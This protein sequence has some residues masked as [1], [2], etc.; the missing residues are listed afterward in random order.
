MSVINDRNQIR[1]VMFVWGVLTLLY[2]FTTWVLVQ[3]V[4]QN[5]Q[6]RIFAALATTVT[7]SAIALSLGQNVLRQTTATNR[8]LQE[9]NARQHEAEAQLR[10]ELVEKQRTEETLRRINAELD[11]LNATTLGLLNRLN[12]EELF[13]RIIARAAALLNT[14][15]GFL[16]VVE[17]EQQELVMRAGVGRYTEYL[18]HRLTRGQGMSGAVWEIGEPM[19]L[20]DYSQ[21]VNRQPG[22]EWVRAQVCL[23]L[24]VGLTIVGVIGLVYLE[25]GRYFSKEAI[26]LLGRFGQLASLALENARL[27][28]QVHQELQ[29]RQHA[30]QQLQETLTEIERAQTKANAIFDAT[31]DSMLLLAP[32]Q[33]ILAVNRSFCEHFFGSDPR[34]AFGHPLTDYQAEAQRLFDPPTALQELIAQTIADTEQSFTQNI[35][36]RAPQR[37]VIQLF[38]TPV[39]T[40]TAEHLGRLYVFRDVTKEREVDRMKSEFVSMVSHELR[41][42]LTSIKGYVDLL[43]TGEV[44]ELANE[45]REFLDIVKTNTD[46]LVELINELL[47][48]SRIEAGGVELKRAALDLPRLVQ[49]VADAMLPQLRAKQHRLTLDLASDLPA[50]WGDR[51]RVIQILTNFVSNAHKY[52]PAGGSITIS[53]R[54]AGDHVRVDICDTGIGLSH[55]DQQQLFSKFFRAQNRATQEVVGTGLGLAITRSLIEMHGGEVWVESEPGKGSTFSFTLPTASVAL[56]PETPTKTLPGKRILIVDDEPD[57]ANLLRHYLERAGYQTLIAHDGKAALL[58]AQT[59][60][61]DLITLDIILPDANGFTVLEWLKSDSD[62]QAIPVIL[63]SIMA[64]EEDGKLLGAVDYLAKPVDERVLLQHVSRALERGQ[65]QRVLVAEDDADRRHLVAEYLRRAGYQV[66]EARDGAQVIRIAKEQ[67][68]MLILL[69]IRMP[70]LDGV[71][72]LS[73]LRAD[74][75]TRHVPVIMMTGY[76]GALEEN[77][78][79][80]A[81]LNAPII[82]TKPFTAEQLVTAIT[83]TLAAGGKP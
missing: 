44:G 8:A 10:Q 39:R 60:H 2:F 42:P 36:Q 27:Y 35:E 22:F 68:P 9:S 61:P 14:P 50:V 24:R 70:R 57:I 7:Y 40:K 78:A 17:S 73:Q 19:V 56:E 69:D 53:A 75:Q 52:T 30:D 72:V 76:A 15:H 31:T 64:D 83:Q 11:A 46:R 34:K 20:D 74:E 59:K 79:T 3:I 54:A 51:D 38:S 45:Q 71:A 16:Y 25:P 62:T 65:P 41:T 67:Q 18:G 13:K 12:P 21:W 63:L 26:E 43:Q 47:D 32:N 28:D 66:L 48:I 81:E 37:R 77:R 6:E 58:L 80:I 23:P 82:L 5:S 1:R 33:T 55:E 29:E 49:Q 4:G